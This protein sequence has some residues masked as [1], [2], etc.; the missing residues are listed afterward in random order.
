MVTGGRDKYT[1]LDST[2]IFSDNVW[3]TVAGKL[4][5]AVWGLKVATINNRVLIFGIV[6]Y[7]CSKVKSISSGG[8]V[9]GGN[10]KILEFN[11]DTESWTEIG[12]MMVARGRHAVSVV[13]YDD[14]AKWCN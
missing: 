2:E 9:V 3:R 12:T 6:Y 1:S 11:F 13:P 4:P 10:K 5:V 7:F 8:H 14:Y